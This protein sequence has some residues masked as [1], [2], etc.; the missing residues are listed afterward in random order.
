MS[1]FAD[2]HRLSGISTRFSPYFL[3][4]IAFRK[5]RQEKA[6][7]LFLVFFVFITVVFFYKRFICDFFN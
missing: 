3:D 4:I 1:L 5:K 7:S 6:N 2:R